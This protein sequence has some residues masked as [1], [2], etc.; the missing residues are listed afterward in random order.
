M[1]KQRTLAV[2]FRDATASLPSWL[3]TG[4]LSLSDWVVA[5]DALAATSLADSYK[6][7]ID[8]GVNDLTAPTAAP[9]W[10]ASMGWTFNG[11]TQYLQTV[12]ILST[13]SIVVQY[14]DYDGA[15][16]VL[17]SF[18]A[19]ANNCSLNVSGG[20]MQMYRGAG[21]Q[22]IDGVM[23]SGVY[24]HSYMDGEYF[25]FR[26]G[27]K[28]AVG[29]NVTGVANPVSNAFLGCVNY[30][31]GG[32]AFGFAAIKELRFGVVNRALTVPEIEALVLALNP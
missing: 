19:A 7:L 15:N 20:K 14:T 12:K 31:V 22:P 3:T 11:S 8:P 26:N 4:G 9:T 18:D 27:V 10:S 28:D 21:S 17:G 32:G 23:T 13:Y 30:P 1:D 5:H 16:F 29:L 24:I 25:G 6:N 2:L